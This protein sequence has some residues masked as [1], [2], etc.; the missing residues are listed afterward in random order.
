M[1]ID[2][3]QKAVN[4]TYFLFKTPSYRKTTAW[5]LIVSFVFGII[6][7]I[8]GGKPETIL[9]TFLYGGTDGILVLAA[10]ALVSALLA[11]FFVSRK[12]FKQGF[13][14]FAF[15]S[16][17]SAVLYALILLLGLT[18]G[19]QIFA[20][21]N[22]GIYAIIANALVLVLWLASTWIALAYNKKSIFL[23]V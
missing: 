15:L 2:I 21:V 11:T 14:Y 13:K 23:C 10:P 4:L 5:L 7:R 9:E 19:K 1:D 20:S 12:Q 16:L 8:A 3:D 6:A 18:V 17:A 22:I